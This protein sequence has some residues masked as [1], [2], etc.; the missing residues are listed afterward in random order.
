MVLDLSLHFSL[1]ATFFVVGNFF[2]SDPDTIKRM[3][4]D[5]H[6]V[7]NHTLTHPYISKMSIS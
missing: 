1:S 2:D 5:G 4:E 3:V 6:I 7:V